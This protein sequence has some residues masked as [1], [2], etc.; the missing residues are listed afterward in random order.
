VIQLWQAA[1]GR[2]RGQLPGHK[3]RVRCVAFAPDGKPLASARESG[4][5][6]SWEGGAGNERL[7]VRTHGPGY[8]VALSPDGKFLALDGGLPSRHMVCDHFPGAGPKGSR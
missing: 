1:V 3:S 8:A 4:T 6:R 2:A 7:R 5:I